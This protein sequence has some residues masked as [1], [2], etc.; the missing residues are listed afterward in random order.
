MNKHVEPIGLMYYTKK[1]VLLYERVFGHKPI[2]DPCDVATLEAIESKE[3][4]ETVCARIQEVLK[5]QV[6][7][8][9]LSNEDKEFLEELQF[10]SFLE[11]ADEGDFALV[12]EKYYHRKFFNEIPNDA[13]ISSLIT[14]F[15]RLW[16][17]PSKGPYFIEIYDLGDEAIFFESYDAMKQFVGDYDVTPYT[18]FEVK[19]HH[20]AELYS[21]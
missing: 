6:F 10:S 14:A 4:F 18:A 19:E 16:E 3:R 11:L 12:T 21:E 2:V 7:N 8:A 13:I 17:L 15:E 5:E 20:A 1:A 9:T